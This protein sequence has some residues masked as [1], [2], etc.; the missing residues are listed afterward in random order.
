MKVLLTLLALGLVTLTACALPVNSVRGSGNVVTESRTVS[1]FDKVTLSG[2]GELDITQGDSESLTIQAD[3]NLMPYITTVVQNGTLEIGLETSRGFVS[4]AA[5]R[6][7][8]YTL[9][10]QNLTALTVS[11][12]GNVQ[13]PALKTTNLTLRT[14][15]A[16]NTTLSGL[17]ASTVNTGLS[18]AGSIV[19]AGTVQTQEAN[20][21][22][23][24]SYNAADL[25]SA[26][27]TVSI[28]GA[29]SATVWA[30]DSLNA[31][32]T[33][34]GSISYYGDPQ[35]TQNITGLGSIRSLGSK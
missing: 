33:G 17:E 14:S 16:G 13:M 31:R 29:G 18:G 7:I 8:K 2:I 9:Q 23:L 12:A 15:G 5:T 27:A 25:A 30:T 11:G 35:V 3:D 32:I 22:G 20:L 4:L 6:G 24:G 34:A 10:V 1:G 19:L 26:S 28:S 21:S